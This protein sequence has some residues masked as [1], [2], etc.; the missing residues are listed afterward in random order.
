MP[1]KRYNTGNQVVG[2]VQYPNWMSNPNMPS[3]SMT[4]DQTAYLGSLYS[5]NDTGTPPTGNFGPGGDRIAGR[6]TRSRRFNTVPGQQ[7]VTSGD[8]QVTK[9]QRR[10]ARRR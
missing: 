10:D 2:A 9:A 6:N 4:D 1:L 5:D 8:M 7:Y 3:S